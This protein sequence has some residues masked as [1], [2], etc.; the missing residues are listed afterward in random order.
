MNRKQILLTELRSVVQG[1]SDDEYCVFHKG[2]CYR[3][4]DVDPQKQF[5]PIQGAKGV[6]RQ[7][8]VRDV[9]VINGNTR[10]SY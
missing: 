6:V 5:A 8:S 2:K 3:P 10:I 9:F 7:R 4:Q 1:S